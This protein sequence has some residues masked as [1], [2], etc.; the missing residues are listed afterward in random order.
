MAKEATPPFMLGP[1]VRI[2]PIFHQRR[3]VFR[4]DTLF[5][6]M[7]FSEPW[8]D[9]I[10]EELQGIGTSQGLE[11][12]RADTRFGPVITE[13]IWA[14]I[15]ESRL[16]IAD[17]TG[18]NANVF[19][20]LGTAHTIGKD[21]ILITQP[22]TRF[23][24]DTQGFRHLIYTDNPAGMRLLR[25]EL[26]KIIHHHLAEKPRVRPA[27]AMPKKTVVR[28]AWMIHTKDWD[29]PLP[30]AQYQAE[31]GQLGVLKKRMQVMTWA[32]SEEEMREFLKEIRGSWPQTWN[33]MEEEE[34]KQRCASLAE[35][36]N[37][38]RGG[39]L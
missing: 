12:E 7:P 6:L 37:S 30:P 8:S 2:E 14:A 20:E 9:R 28:A 39:R 31:R 15:V 35:I 19:Y 4:P 10:W 36:I 23:P 16:I 18:W 11:V 13:D 17:V 1:Y 22:T 33:G 5:V 24:F 3:F 32:F 25:K 38:W 21:V 27:F 26:P 34:I 29:P